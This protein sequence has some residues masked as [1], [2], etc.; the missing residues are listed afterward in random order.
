M[1]LNDDYWLDHCHGFRVDSPAER[2]GLVEDVLF[3]ARL[4]RPDTLLVR[5]GRLDRRLIAVPVAD[6]EEVTPSLG[7]IALSRDPDELR[8]ERRRGSGARARHWGRRHLRA[9]HV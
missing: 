3:R 2:V 1:H 4:E 5:R 8:L 6:V 7:H 9:T